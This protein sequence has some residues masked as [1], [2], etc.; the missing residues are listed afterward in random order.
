[1]AGEAGEELSA[2]VSSLGALNYIAGRCFDTEGEVHISGAI[3]GSNVPVTRTFRI[4]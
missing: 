4:P 2:F 1:M 3:M